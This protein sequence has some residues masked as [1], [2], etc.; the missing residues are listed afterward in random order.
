[1]NENK[2]TYQQTNQI[3]NTFLQSLTIYNQETIPQG[4]SEI[5]G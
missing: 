1:M 3:F 5:Q 4:K 2:K